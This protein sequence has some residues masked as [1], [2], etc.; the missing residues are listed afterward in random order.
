MKKKLSI[1]EFRTKIIKQLL[2]MADL[3]LRSTQP[4]THV[5]AQTEK[6]KGRKIRKQL[7]YKNLKSAN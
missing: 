2:E 7:C 6:F 1:V 5:I 4:K 3:P